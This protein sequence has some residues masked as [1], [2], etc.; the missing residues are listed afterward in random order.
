MTIPA[1]RLIDTAPFRRHRRSL[2]LSLLLSSLLLAAGCNTYYIPPP[3]TSI[4]LDSAAPS[5][6]ITTVDSNGATVPNTLQFSGRVF[7]NAN[8]TVLYSVGYDGQYVP[9][10]DNIYGT[11]SSSGVYTAPAVVP[12]PNVVTV[13]AV[14]QADPTQT[15]TATITLLNPPANVTSVSPAVVTAGQSYT[16]DLTGTNF[17]PGSTVNVSGAQTGTPQLL[18]ATEI[19]VPVAVNASG[20]LSISVVNPDAAGMANTA[21]LRSQPSAPPAS[22]AVAVLIAKVGQNGSV[23]VTGTKA[24]VPLQATLAVVNLDAGRQMQS[25][26]MP[27]GYSADLAAADPV[28]QHVVVASRTSNILQIVDANTDQIIGSLTTPASTTTTVDG[29]SCEICALMVDSSHGL[30]ILDTANG[31]LTVNLATGAASAPLAAPAAAN[32]AYNPATERIYAPVGTG[33]EV[34]DLVQS[35]VSAARIA[36]GNVLYGTGLDT[37]AF[38]AG[39]A[40]LTVGDKNSGTYL[41][42]NFNGALSSGSDVQ[43]AASP[44]S[45][46]AGCAGLWNGVNLDPTTHVGWFAN[47]GACIAIAALP[48]AAASGTPG[49]PSHIV[50]ARVPA[51]PDGGGWVNTPTGEPS[52]LAVY[53]G[54]DSH[55][56]GL[57][58]RGDRQVLLKTDLTLLT[59]AA[60]MAGSSDSTQVD[61]T[62]ATA[63]GQTVSALDYINLH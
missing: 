51:G 23:A 7:N 27:N 13:Q 58:L 20:L 46:G 29:A 18:S 56:Y 47:Q 53:I 4:S 62:H 39:T 16:L 50:W 36:G 12:T 63:N 30:A 48:P 11:I 57:A 54:A 21:S 42:L 6:V 19:K 43:V 32:F 10:G 5:L 14:A 1:R 60:P 38:D 15:A 40:L 61:P 9:G 2:V 31:Y 52:T 59:T 49:P 26:A 22:S 55:T 3:S 45:F 35:S 17:A 37:A 24:Y 34:I 25:V 41:S 28:H 8:T 33:V 44:F